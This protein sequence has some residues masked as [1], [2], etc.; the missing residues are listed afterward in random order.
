[1]YSEI[2]TRPPGY[3]CII[4]AVGRAVVGTGSPWL[5]VW[6]RYGDDLPSPQTHVDSMGIFNQP[7][8]TR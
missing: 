7:E 1:M 5:W 2:N 4:T 3:T 6:G 8:I